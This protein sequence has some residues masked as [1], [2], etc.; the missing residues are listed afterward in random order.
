M[1]AVV[2]SVLL[3]LTL[4]LLRLNVVFALAI[5]ALAAGLLGG[6]SL[7]DTIKHF[8]AGLSNG[9][10]IA[11]SYAMLGAFAVAI[12]RSGLT[13]TLASAII[14]KVAPGQSSE[15]QHHS[16]MW[17]KWGLLSIILL[18][19]IASQNAIPVH[20]AFIPLLIPPL[21][22]VFNHFSYDRRAVACILTFG[23]AT[24]YMVLPLGFGA[25]YLNNI[26]HKNLTLNG[27]SIDASAMS[28]A[29]LIPA[30]GMVIGLAIALGISYRK[31]RHYADRNTGA[32]DQNQ[33]A[34]VTTNTATATTAPSKVWQSL[35]AVVLS[36]VAQL[37][38]NSIIIGAMTGLALLAATGVI[39]LRENQQVIRK[40]VNMMAMI[41][42]IMITANGYSEV[43]SQTGHVQ[44]L[45]ANLTQWFGDSKGLAAA[46]MLVVGL[47]ITMGIGSSF[48]TVPIIAAIYVPICIAMGFSPLATA[49][50]VGTAGALGDA[51]S[52]ASDSTLGPTAGLNADE[53]HDHIWDTVVPT[54][55]HFNIPLLITGWI[56]AMTL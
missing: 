55:I 30:L 13:D 24:T 22:T 41:G 56:A 34:G 28:S 35:L 12:S 20:I 1:N 18:M 40:G 11:L 54:F 48:S 47:L 9:A 46:F 19:S 29:M 10:T 49:A 27:L 38:T 42:F 51:G 26:L 23:L 43:V 32:T 8:E 4:S 16:Q 21:L 44:S 37:Y 6:L 33:S 39:K 14:R 45:V 5:S 17:V 50:I 53:Q 15:R 25:I 52:P 36:L 31:P 3:M 7:N 2:I